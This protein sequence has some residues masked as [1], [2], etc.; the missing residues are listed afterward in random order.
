MYF[1]LAILPILAS[2]ATLL[3]TVAVSAQ[4]EKNPTPANAAASIIPANLSHD[5]VAATVNGEKLLVGDVKKI[6]EARPYPFTL[7]EEQ[8]KQLRHAALE[9]LIE[10]A[11]MRQYFNKQVTQI[12]Q[13]D[14]N[15]EWHGICSPP[16]KRRRGH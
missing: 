16:C 15:K 10:D 9:V 14:F 11:V 1:R 7:K 5:A 2:A 6:L 12:N 3:L 8:K 13:A 4:T